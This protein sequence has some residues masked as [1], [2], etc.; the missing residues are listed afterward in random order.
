MQGEKRRVA[1]PFYIICDT[2]KSMWGGSEPTPY[3]A[4]MES[5]LALVD[6]AED[7]VEA[8]DIA[9]LGIITFS[10]D[11]QVAY[12][13]CRLRG[14][15]SAP[16]FQK[17]IFTNY[18]AAF[19]LATE[20]LQKDIERLESD[21]C[22]VKRPSIFFITDGYPCIDGEIQPMK[23]WESELNRLQGVSV[24]R[25]EGPIKPAIIAMG[26]DNAE[27]TTLKRVA[28]SPGLACV[29]ESRAAE[30]DVL[31]SRLLKSILRSISRSVSRDQL[32]FAPPPGMTLC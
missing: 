5:L 24:K 1:W 10:D 4:M 8:A 27:R 25:Q 29:A 32:E 31:M 12:P 21:G 9:H 7:N 14:G 16:P 2:S 19:S 11:A 13:L 3:T 18:R 15:F 22:R 23:E 28:Q 30:P 26:F 20:T 17:G 6:F